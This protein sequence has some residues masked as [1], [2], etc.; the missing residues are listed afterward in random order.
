MAVKH[1]YSIVT[2]HC[3][4]ELDFDGQNSID[5][6]RIEE[7]QQLLNFQQDGAFGRISKELDED[8]WITDEVGQLQVEGSEQP[9]NFWNILR[10]DFRE[11]FCR[12]VEVFLESFFSSNI[13]FDN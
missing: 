5:V 6:C 13:C 4:V 12:N 10:I 11:R 7:R 1:V 2:R 8:T 9:L 3:F